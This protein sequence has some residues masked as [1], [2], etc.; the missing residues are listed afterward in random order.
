MKKVFGIFL[1]TG[2]LFSNCEYLEDNLPESLTDSEVIEGLKTALNVGVDTATNTL[3]ATNG[4][5]LDEA[6]KILLPPE[7]EIITSNLSKVASYIPGGQELIQDQLDDLILSINRAAEDAANDALPILTDAVASLSIE[8]G[9]DILNGS[10]PSSYKSTDSDFDSIAA[11]HYMEQET[12]PALIIAFSAPIN[13][14][15]DKPLIGNSS[16]NDIWGTITSNYNS[17]VEIY[18]LIPLI[19]DLETVNSN[20]GEYAT[21]K[22]LDGLFLKVGEEEKKIRKDPWQWSLDILHRVF[23]SLF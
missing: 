14:S 11:T 13:N 4:Y 5:F 12:K 21:E 3:H 7:A 23:G 8:D 20:L 2:L 15:L 22:A 10:V 6:V 16:T 18:N 9:W 1:L 19:A 17:A